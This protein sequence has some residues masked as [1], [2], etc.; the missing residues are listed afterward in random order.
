MKA[1][2]LR[3]LTAEELSQRVQSDEEEL[4]RLRFQASTGV[5]ENPTRIRVLRPRDCSGPDHPTRAQARAAL[6]GS[7]QRDL[8]VSSLEAG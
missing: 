4:L 3:E 5:L 2:E 6:S 7:G 8:E 1:T